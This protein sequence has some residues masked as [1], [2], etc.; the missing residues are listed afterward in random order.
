MQ[1]SIASTIMAQPRTEEELLEREDRMARQGLRRTATAL[2]EDLVNATELRTQVSKHPLAAMAAGLIG[3]LFLAR[4][5][6]RVIGPRE[7]RAAA[8]F[9]TRFAS[10][11]M[12]GKVV[13]ALKP[14]PRRNGPF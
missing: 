4:P 9:A 8:R 2:G 10:V 7:L 12:L 11:G 1:S 3:G 13:Q 5:L 6:L 14:E